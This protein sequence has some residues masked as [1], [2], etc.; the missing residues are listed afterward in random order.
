VAATAL[1]VLA[2]PALA[3]DDEGTTTTTR[4]STTTTTRASSTTS[5]TEPDD[6]STTTTGPSSTTSTTSTSSTSSS[7]STTTTSTTLPSDVVPPEVQAM[8]DA[9]PRTP[10]GSTRDLVAALAD[11]PDAAT[12]GGFG[13]FPVGGVA[14]WSHDWLFPRHEPTLHYHEGTDVFADRGTPVLAPAA[15][16]ATVDTGDVGGLA[17]KVTQPDGTIWYLAHLDTA[18]IQ[19]STPVTPG[20]VVGTAGDTGNAAGGAPHVHV[21]VW[22]HG[23]E[24]IDP[25]PIL[26]AYAAE[27]L[28]AAP[29]W[30]AD[31]RLA[32]LRAGVS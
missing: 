16:I 10:P 15:G 18:V 11:E 13:R 24:P 30:L 7:T 3:A 27:A 6:E 12:T 2:V 1:L 20:V 14:T 23:G 26:D 32:L 19:D 31:L 25:K 22:P 29:A 21:E 28:A 5:T 17:V 9:Y 4:P 8:I